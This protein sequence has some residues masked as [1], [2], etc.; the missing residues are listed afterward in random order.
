MQEL[1]LLLHQVMGSEQPLMC[2]W[3]CCVQSCRGQ[4]GVSMVLRDTPVLSEAGVGEGCWGMGMGWWGPRG[5][6]WL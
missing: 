4:A 6:S 2:P 3:L 1:S 5:R